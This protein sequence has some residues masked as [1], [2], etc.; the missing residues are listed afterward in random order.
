MDNLVIYILL[1]MLIVGSFQM[2]SAGILMQM[3]TLKEVRRHFEFYFLG[4]AVYA[5]LMLMGYMGSVVWEQYSWVA[6]IH[7]FGGAC[8]L[9]LYHFVILAMG[10]RLRYLSKRK[11]RKSM[12]IGNFLL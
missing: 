3:T 11:R 4:V 5:V 1:A 12:Q 7:F 6:L 8:F 10:F 2:V 9:A